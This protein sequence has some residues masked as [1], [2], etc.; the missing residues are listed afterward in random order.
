MNAVSIN[1]PTPKFTI[2]YSTT[3]IEPK[4]LTGTCWE[5]YV[6]E[7][8]AIERNNQLTL[9][10]KFP[11]MRPFIYEHDVRNLSSADRFWIEK[12]ID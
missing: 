3:T 1:T 6:D 4:G 10:G 9:E 7:K 8:F 5:F 2:F 12:K 11:I